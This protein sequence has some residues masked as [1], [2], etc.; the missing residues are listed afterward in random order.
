MTKSDLAFWGDT[1]YQGTYQGF[2]II[3]ISNPEEPSAITEYDSCRG[4]QGDVI[5]WENILVRS[6]N[7]PA[8]PGGTPPAL[9][10]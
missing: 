3:D 8:T 2:R 5:V 10:T 9:P 4:S 7:G 1:A 6:W